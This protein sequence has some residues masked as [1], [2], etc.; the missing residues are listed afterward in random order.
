M[1]GRGGLA[2]LVR[3]NTCEY[4]GAREGRVGLSAVRAL[5]FVLKYVAGPAV[6]AAA[7]VRAARRF[8]AVAGV[9]APRLPPSLASVTDLRSSVLPVRGST[10]ELVAEDNALL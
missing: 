9:V 8:P 7:T 6:V 1:R 5:S 3:G 2:G 10:E 4:A